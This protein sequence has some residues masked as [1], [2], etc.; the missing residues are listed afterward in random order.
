MLLI[1]VLGQFTTSSKFHGSSDLQ[2]TA[3]LSGGKGDTAWQHAQL[4]RQNVKDLNEFPLDI[5]L[6]FAK[7]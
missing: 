6:H 7:K 1:C 5:T 3:T 4:F 2:L